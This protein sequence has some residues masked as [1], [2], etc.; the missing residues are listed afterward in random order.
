MTYHYKPSRTTGTRAGLHTS[1]YVPDMGK[2]ASSSETP[3]TSTAPDSHDQGR[4]NT[5]LH[6]FISFLLPWWFQRGLRRL[7]MDTIR[8]E[9][10]Q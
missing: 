8:E 6:G 5:R 3:P 1:S 4:E 7:L 9:E 2:W 10:Q